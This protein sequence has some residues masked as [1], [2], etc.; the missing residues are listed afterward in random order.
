MSSRVASKRLLSLFICLLGCIIPAIAFAQSSY[1]LKIYNNESGL[2]QNYIYALLQDTNGYLWI[3]TGEGLAQFDG[4]KMHVYTSG[5][6]LSENFVTSILKH[7]NGA[8]YIGHYQGGISKKTEKGIQKLTIPNF[9]SPI[10]Q[11]LEG[12]KGELIIVSQN[13]GVAI[14]NNKD[15]LIIQQP[16]ADVLIYTAAILS[17]NKIALGTSDGVL[18]LDLNQPN[19][20]AT[21][22]SVPPLKVNALLVDNE[23]GKLW[24]GTDYFG[25]YAI[26]LTNFEHAKNYKIEDGLSDNQIQ[27]LC[28][29]LD[30]NLWIGGRNNLCFFTPKEK[31]ISPL[32]QLNDL[33]IYRIMCD[34]E[35]NII[36]GLY[37]NGLGI[38]SKRFYQVLD[39]Q[40]GLDIGKTNVSVSISHDS[41]L[42]AAHNGLW[43]VN[44]T[45]TASKQLIK[46][47]QSELTALAID[48][49]NQFALVGTAENGLF[50]FYLKARKSELKQLLIPEIPNSITTIKY[51]QNYWVIG[52]ITGGVILLD[53]DFK[54]VKQ[55]DTSTA[56]PLNDALGIAFT[57]NNE[58]FL[59]MDGTSLCYI[60]SKLQVSTSRLNSDVKAFNFRGFS[61]S[62]KNTWIATQG[63]G[64][65]QIDANDSVI[66]I[67]SQ[68]GLLSDYVYDLCYVN[69]NL[70]A[71]SRQGFTILNQ[72]KNTIRSFSN[73][74]LK[75]NQEYT[76]LGT[77]SNNNGTIVVP[78]SNGILLIDALEADAPSHPPTI[79]L[80]K[81]I[82][83]D[84]PVSPTP[85]SFSYDNYKLE[86][87]FTGISFKNP[88]KVKY[89]YMLEGFDAEW[90][91]MTT[92]TTVRYSRVLDGNYIFK[93]RAINSDG[94]LS[95]TA[96]TFVFNVEKP[97]WKKWWF[98][99]ILSILLIGSIYFI[100]SYRTKKLLQRQQ[101][102]EK[103]V[104]LRTQELKEERD[105][106]I[107]Q[108]KIISDYNKDIRASI[109]YARRI[110]NAALPTADKFDASFAQ[111]MIFYQP[112][113][114]VSGDFYW[115]HKVGNELFIAVADCTGHGVPGAFMSMLGHSG[116]NQAVKERQLTRPVEILEYIHT[117]LVATLKQSQSEEEIR[118]G[119]DI[120]ILR[121]NLENREVN[122]AGA[123]NPLYIVPANGLI[124]DENSSFK[125]DESGLVEIKGDKLMIGFRDKYAANIFYQ[126]HIFTL[127]VGDRMYML[128]DGFPDQFGGNSFKKFKYA[129]LKKLIVD[130]KN[131]PMKQQ[132][133]LF[134]ETFAS[135]K[136]DN[137]QTDDVLVLGIELC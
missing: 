112:K 91:E 34:F 21:I 129:N 119:M 54:F 86:F 26:D 40:N 46:F 36:M 32:H 93:V 1:Q 102:L 77:F 79:A 57:K 55:F 83:N 125:A 66:A 27:A 61:Q 81:I 16:I 124:M 30:G 56:L 127:N 71:F 70:F 136:G 52:T 113:D 94:E 28:K 39:K 137:P 99:L 49:N 116:L 84:N 69:D 76:S 109:N 31:F 50:Q 126:E 104:D 106:V 7:T 135:W 73:S 103:L 90:S 9:Y 42:V 97:I 114:I 98:Y 88:E 8:T 108:N 62:A 100:I 101:E 24:V 59:S 29:D 4:R 74:D 68:N 12:K 38:L 120:V 33:Y 19:S 87:Q 48:P 78:S 118:D 82:V 128:S 67:T 47:E 96:A 89:Q 95:K 17:E 60:D 51:W 5:D 18:L 107:T 111:H 133:A 2:P 11:L 58:L 15:T 65:L 14:I 3:G 23:A 121:V 117:F 80:E 85:L 13:S 123:F 64:L 44:T 92:T 115:S 10:N 6:S 37:G 122:F 20:S 35:G 45:T 72:E 63:F 131:M 25:L 130:N 75:T 132:E 110:Q 134:R 105:V 43:G 53:N 22:S 41:L